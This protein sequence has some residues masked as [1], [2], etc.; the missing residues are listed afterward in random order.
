MCDV[1]AGDVLVA[2]PTGNEGLERAVRDTLD[3]AEGRGI[4]V[5]HSLREIHDQFSVGH[6]EYPYAHQVLRL[7]VPPGREQASAAELYRLFAWTAYGIAE[8]GGLSTGDRD[9]LRTALQ[10]LDPPFHATANGLWATSSGLSGHEFRLLS[11]HDDALSAIGATTSRSAQGVVIGVLDTGI[12]P[13]HEPP[14]VIERLNAMNYDQAS[15]RNDVQDGTGHGTLVTNL[16]SSV[17]DDADYKIVKVFTSSGCSTDWHVML[18][19]ALLAGC[20]VVNLSVESGFAGERMR[21]GAIGHAAVSSLF[22]AV[23]GQGVSN[24]SSIYVAAAGNSGRTH[25]A[26]PARLS[27]VVAVASINGAGHLSAFSNRGE[28]DHSGLPHP[29]VFAAPGGE[30]AA[31]GSVSEEDLAETIDGTS[32]FYGTSFAAAYATGAVAAHISRARRNGAPDDRLAVLGAMRDS[33]SSDPSWYTYEH[34]NGL[35]RLP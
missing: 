11:A 33:A 27:D 3:V 20:D 7:S 10:R 2:Y 35:V 15:L 32:K 1:A 4:R 8:H 34:G 30:Y 19:L 5:R 28:S 16:I 31:D 17:V 29:W 18:G 25:L 22:E 24:S 9:E 26:Y 13:Q 14:S 12:D 21:C 6:V 23:V